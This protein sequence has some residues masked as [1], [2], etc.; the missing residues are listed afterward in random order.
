MP[1][2]FYNLWSLIPS[3]SR[4]LRSHLVV[5]AFLGLT[6][7]PS[8]S[9]ES[10][11]LF[12]DLRLEPDAAALTAYG[13]SILRPDAKV[14]FEAGHSRGNR[15]FAHL[16]DLKGG[17]SENAALDAA[18]RGFNGYVF[19]VREKVPAEG[20]L[21]ALR[22]VRAQLPDKGILLAG[23]F[24]H[25]AEAWP[26][27]EGVLAQG[28]FQNPNA[29]SGLIEPVPPIESLPL[30]KVLVEARRAGLA[31]FVMD[32]AELEDS[33]ATAR[34]AE[35]IEALGA[36]AFITDD[37]LG[38]TI[39][40]PWR[41][42][43]RTV[44]VVHGWNP[45][46]Q[47]GLRAQP[48]STLVANRLHAPLEWLGYRLEYL[49]L[50]EKALPLSL[51]G[52]TA[53]IL[54]STLLLTRR[55]QAE[56]A[57]WISTTSAGQIPILLT[58]QPWTDPEIF[59]A[60]AAP[61][62]LGGSGQTVPGLKRVGIARLNSEVTQG[63]SPASSSTLGFYDLQAPEG[64][65]VFLSLRG[66]ASLQA[67]HFDAAFLTRWG[68][69]LMDTVG[70]S[71]EPVL[72]EVSFLQRWLADVPT[73]PIP[74]TTTRDGRRMLLLQTQ[75]EGFSTTATIPGLITCGELTKT[76]ILDCYRLPF[77]VGL[78]EAELRGWLPGLDPRDALR[79]EETARQIL[80]LPQV[81]PASATFSR[82]SNW[83]FS[84]GENENPDLNAQATDPRDGLGRQIGG[85]L[86][87]IHRQI[88][89]SNKRIQF[90]QWPQRTPANLDSVAYARRMGA[91]SLI[92]D[93][94]PLR[95]TRIF[96]HA[97]QKVVHQSF[98]GPSS[99]ESAFEESPAQ[100]RT[101]PLSFAFRF[102]DARTT[103]QLS[104]VKRRL[105]LCA[106]QPLQPVRATDYVQ[107]VEDAADTRILQVAT[108][109]W[110]ILNQ[111]RARTFRFP[112]SM[113]VPH[114][115]RCRGVSGY[116]VRGDQIYV[117]TLGVPSTELVMTDAQLEQDHIYLQ[118]ASSS[119]RFHQLSAREVEF[120]FRDLRIGDVIFAGLMPESACHITLNGQRWS[121]LANASG[122]LSLELPP[123]GHAHIQIS[124]PAYAAS[125]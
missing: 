13:V 59:A 2:L 101:A 106:S 116:Q 90:V 105:D 115:Q 114:L 113:G 26:E 104:E 83:N 9:A 110:I 118:Q 44:L 98:L 123:Q 88:L 30:Q 29:D 41:E 81:E 39:V 70:P 61:L 82:P 10:H 109:H 5:A 48:E 4:T 100:R 92:S 103:D 3:R 50:G 117:H 108:G 122:H 12:V 121:V 84:E 1:A 93:A 87:Y 124:P 35:N 91:L 60:L 18:K 94:S 7:A 72:D 76:R 66:D 86:A 73:F 69:V 102:D 11:R 51:R 68:G 74:D 42:Q 43:S 96:D 80:S 89:P 24:W 64:A 8:I 65:D 56:L 49:D 6:T 78:C 67:A 58:G 107:L 57:Q 32:F 28:V 111:G 54:D 99:P 27:V 52:I 45:A 34:I 23:A 97:G 125:R 53:V 120:E 36:S 37:S 15:F 119:L 19:N 14:D 63:R 40:G 112:A 38:G 22:A 20:Q 25:L 71:T 21:S 17:V 79:Y 47:N 46:H 55:E 95:R 75:S 77:T 62:Q 16:G 31:T 85:S 33:K